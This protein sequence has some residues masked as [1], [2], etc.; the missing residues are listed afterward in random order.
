M[1]FRRPDRRAWLLVLIA[2]YA[3]PQAKDDPANA[4]RELQSLDPDTTL[5]GRESIKRLGPRA[6]PIVPAIVEMLKWPNPYSRANAALALGE[7]GDPAQSAVPT[8]IQLL[9]DPNTDIRGTAAEALGAIG[10][11]AR[12]A[13]PALTNQLLTDHENRDSAAAAL[14]DIGPAAAAAVPALIE[15]MCLDDKSGTQLQYQ[16]SALPALGRI[17]P[18]AVAA[19]TQ[20][21]KEAKCFDVEAPLKALTK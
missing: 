20:T 11:A 7:I 6:A 1:F 17:G 9:N 21:M 16:V 2:T 14:G 4:L 19:L 12:D 15:E 3:L 10:P 18:V 13:V 5:A 8:I